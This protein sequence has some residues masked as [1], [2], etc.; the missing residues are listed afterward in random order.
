[1]QMT[2]NGGLKRGGMH[3][4]RRPSAIEN[5][6][7]ARYFFH[8]NSSLLKAPSIVIHAEITQQ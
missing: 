5:V 3:G 6:S 2:E 1:M 8:Q 7:S 4:E